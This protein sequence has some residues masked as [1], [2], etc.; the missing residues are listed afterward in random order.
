MGK[1]LIIKGADFSQVAILPRQ[2]QWA[3]AYSDYELQQASSGKS[4]YRPSNPDDVTY[5]FSSG[6]DTPLLNH[7][8]RRVK[9]YA[10]RTGSLKL[11]RLDREAFTTDSVQIL[12]VTRTGLVEID[13]TTP[14]LVDTTHTV[15]IAYTEDTATKYLEGSALGYSFDMVTLSTR[16][17]GTNTC[18]FLI[19]YLF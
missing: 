7:T 12:S 11:M 13:L 2:P 8:I 9:F 18:T 19:D 3:F 16:T 15:G 10:V 1:S 4:F 14:I 5:A 17:V 6:A